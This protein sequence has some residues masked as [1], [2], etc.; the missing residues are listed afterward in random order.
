MDES[1][2][3]EY[4]PPLTFARDVLQVRLWDKQQQVLAAL[5][6]HRRVA[7][8]SGNGLGKGFCAA[9]AVLWFIHCHDPAIVLSTA[10]HLPAGAARPLE[11]DPP[12]VQAG[13]GQSGRLHV[14]HSLGAGRGPLRH[15]TVRRIR[16]RVPG[17]PLPQHA[18]RGGRGRRGERR[19]IRG[20]RVGDDLRRTPAAAHRQ[21]QL[22]YPGP[23][24][25]PSTRSAASITP[26]PSLPWTAPTCGKTG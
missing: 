21:S 2:A 3:P 9:V 17:L 16:G 10:P 19:D 22:P 14:E 26:S 25:G 5:A 4:T 1:P 11:T 23:S 24:A 20:H 8:K 13:H 7:V 12:P 6:A 18:H 15:G